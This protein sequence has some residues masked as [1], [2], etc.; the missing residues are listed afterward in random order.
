MK[1]VL[2]KCSKETIQNRIRE[3][4]V[5]LLAF[6]LP[7]ITMLALFAAQQIYPFGNRSF[8]N[9]D[10]YHQYFPF[11]TDFFHKLKEGDSLYYSWNAGI[12]SN[13]IALYAYYLATP[14]NWF[15]V[16]I[17]ESYLMEFMSYL[18][19]VK[20]GLC[21]LTS[22][23]YFSRRFQ[24][25]RIVIAFFA[26]FYAM[27][28][29]MAAYNWNVMWLDCIVLAP[30]IL[31]GLEVL[32]KEG[33][34]KL[35]CL[36]LGLAIMSNYYICIMIC[37]YLVLYFL[38]VL[39]PLAEKKLAACL[40]F[41]VFSLLA[42][43]IGALFLI[44]EILALR[45]SRFTSASFPDTLKSYFSLFDV[46]ARHCMDVAIE[47][48]LDH[49]PNIYCSVAVILL[50]PLYLMSKSIASKEKTG[51]IVLLI[52][53]L[54][55]F[56]Y[57]IP[58]FIWHG[59]NYPDSLPARQSFLYILL[60]LTVCLEAFLHIRSAS[61]QE[62]S[63]SCVT[64]VLFVLFVQKLVTDDAFCAE[65]YLLTAIFLVMYAVLLHL[66]HN[67]EKTPLYLTCLIVLLV[68]IEAGS[69]TLLTS[70]STV[71]RP[72]YL[73]NYETFHDLS[74]EQ[75]LVDEG[76]FYRYEKTSR[77]TNNDSMLQDYP[78]VSMF[79]STGNGLVNYFY[80]RYGMRNSKVYYC[81]DGLTP[82]TSALL[83][84]G[85][86]FSKGA[87][88]PE[89][90]LYSFVKEQD[91][92]Y[93]YKNTYAL[94][95]GFCISPDATMEEYLID[96]KDTAFS[97]VAENK[98]DDILPVKR[99]NMLARRLGAYGDIFTEI[100]SEDHAGYS[101][102]EVP[103]DTHVY[104]YCDTTKVPEITAY[105]GDT[106]LKTYKKLNNKYIM[107]LGYHTA[108]TIITLKS[109]TE[110][111]FYLTAYGMDE[112]CLGDLVRRLGSN[113]MDIEKMDSDTLQ[114]TITADTD[115][116]LVFS[117]P[118]D[119]GFTIL[120]DGVKTEASLFEDMMIA[121]PLT[122][123]TH[124]ISLEY[125]PQGMTAGIV[126]T[127]FSITIFITICIFEQKR[128]KRDKTPASNS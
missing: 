107:N 87:E 61:K 58:T 84:C 127:L 101:T 15:C 12:G 86:L 96:D 74:S 113:T 49:W 9:I 119:P 42:G 54:L 90:S 40:R 27:S 83:S 35:Y 72:N 30:L 31:L 62:L 85:Y 60:V 52:I 29:Y 5:F 41:A 91:N 23:I 21:G 44:P 28:G 68:V 19:V 3:N 2:K 10:M 94:P 24:S 76:T 125:Y 64:A 81:A 18:V 102:I 65:T 48:G 108:G 37:I 57:N 50:F 121:I 45:L 82:F 122:A 70:L 16:L 106:E 22:A 128:R 51:K 17:P 100:Y 63:I 34:Y 7:F 120:V 80:S 92:V 8:L 97:I 93:L 36:S 71:S 78:S 56:S 99:Q 46:L 13:F 67:H 88:L 98:K 4:Q 14:I 53:M 20:I 79:S 33:K 105:V 77:V 75:M 109:E 69:N 117:I 115:G 114:G 116:Y 59:F 66:F 89:D 123:G 110:K 126:T 43:G 25:K 39:L 95:L 55:S 1:F 26:L 124:S 47:T 118:Y 73:A 32:V 111:T 6:A 38:I 11:L 112:D 104:A 103:Y